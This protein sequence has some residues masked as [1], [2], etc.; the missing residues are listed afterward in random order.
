[1]GAAPSV[2]A[3]GNPI[4]PAAGGGGGNGG[5]ISA[6]EVG[7]G[8]AIKMLKQREDARKAAASS[9]AALQQTQAENKALQKEVERRS[10]LMRYQASQIER[11]RVK[12]GT[13]AEQDDDANTSEVAVHR[14]VADSDKRVKSIVA[15]LTN[16]DDVVRTAAAGTLAVLLGSVENMETIAR[17]GGVA[18]LSA[19]LSGQGAHR[20][21][22]D[23]RLEA[24]RAL[25]HLAADVEGRR[26]MVADD[27][28]GKHPVAVASLCAVLLHGGAGGEAE[29]NECALNALQQVWA[30]GG[31]QARDALY[32]AG[33]IAAVAQVL[34][35][36][37]GPD[38]GRQL[39]VECL[40]QFFVR[41]RRLAYGAQPQPIHTFM[42]LAMDARDLGAECKERALRLL[43]AVFGTLPP[44]LQVLSELVGAVRGLIRH[45]NDQSLLA[46]QFYDA[47]DALGN[48]AFTE[49]ARPV[50]GALGG[51]SMLSRCLLSPDI[52]QAVQISA[53]GAI[54][55]LSLAETSLTLIELTQ[56]P[57]LPS[58][59]R[60]VGDGD[61]E[62]QMPALQVV[63]RLVA[64]S[65]CDCDSELAEVGCVVELV[66][67]MSTGANSAYGS[68]PSTAAGI[69][70]MLATDQAGESVR[71]AFAQEDV[72]Q[73]LRDSFGAPEPEI[74]ELAHS[75]YSF[76]L[77]C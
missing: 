45:P 64:S 12:V 15:L 33:A 34:S 70:Q 17:L 62:L 53:V 16:V 54:Q 4:E 46:S 60:C 44:D 39:A 30:A 71:F 58:L 7:A 24:C 14:K 50:I 26:R 35:S 77:T 57:I 51:L 36:T 42:E 72:A 55:E 13:D 48:L 28:K 1:M 2:D 21:S 61:A 5:A 56:P 25:R 18:K 67:A 41:R 32:G 9:G 68:V 52:R 74:S 8:L 10:T 59:S 23:A 73:L 38:T 11:L 47:G 63:Q 20:P 69:L 37:A 49:S 40:D 27:G 3:K 76:S 75:L 29:A 43:E 19:L 31:E 22:A 6:P 66:R 65:E